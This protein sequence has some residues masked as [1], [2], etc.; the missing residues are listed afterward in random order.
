MCILFNFFQF[1]CFGVDD[2]PTNYDIIWHK[3]VGLDGLNCLADGFGGILKA[4][5]P[6]IQV[7]AA[8]ADGVKCLIRHATG[9]GELPLAQTRGF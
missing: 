7:D 1:T 6:M 9:A 3:R 4:L 8:L 5:Q 2:K